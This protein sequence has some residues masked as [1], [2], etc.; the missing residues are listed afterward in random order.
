[1]PDHCSVPG[2]DQPPFHPT[3]LVC[4]PSCSE[5]NGRYGKSN[6]AVTGSRETCGFVSSQNTLAVSRET[7]LFLQFHIDSLVPG[8][9]SGVGLEQPSSLGT[10]FTCHGVC[11]S[12]RQGPLSFLPLLWTL[13]NCSKGPGEDWGNW[14]CLPGKAD[15]LSN[16]PLGTRVELIKA[17]SLTFATCWEKI[18]GETY[19]SRR[20]KRAR[21]GPRESLVQGTGRQT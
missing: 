17:V 15:L 11:E 3:V 13:C 1:M 7:W 4:E 12:P 16:S 21:V 6:E 18:D 2:T 9:P 14:T 20:D 5:T 19:S 8:V 10:I